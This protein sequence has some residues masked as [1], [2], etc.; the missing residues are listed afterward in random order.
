MSERGCQSENVSS[1]PVSKSHFDRICD[2][3]MNSCYEII[4]EI[5][6]SCTR[7]LSL[8]KRLD[9]S[10]GREYPLKESHQ[11]HGPPWRPDILL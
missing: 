8:K 10:D 4:L 11:D 5:F 1:Q 2:G 3:R 7:V 6:W 9:I